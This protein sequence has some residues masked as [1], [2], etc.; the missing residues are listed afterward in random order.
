MEVLGW[1]KQLNINGWFPIA[2]FDYISC[3][4]GFVF[5]HWR[6]PR[7]KLMD[8]KLQETPMFGGN[9][10]IVS[11]RCSLKLNTTNDWTPL[12]CIVTCDSLVSWRCSLQPWPWVLARPMC[13]PYQ[14]YMGMCDLC[15]E[16]SS[17][18]KWV[19]ALWTS[20]KQWQP[21]KHSVEQ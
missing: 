4:P 20:L 7:R 15:S 21:P 19:D 12:V 8:P 14:T 6:H 18:E 10:N 3:W 2:M 13:D 17:R 5:G 9:E 1:E 11:C 16:I